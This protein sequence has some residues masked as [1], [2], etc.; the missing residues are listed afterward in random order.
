MKY[1]GKAIMLIRK[2]NPG[3]PDFVNL[4][5]MAFLNGGPSFTLNLKENVTI[6]PLALVV[7]L[8]SGK[9]GFSLFM[10]TMEML[11][12]QPMMMMIGLLLTM[13]L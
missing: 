10:E 6:A 4:N 5:M 9:P 3:H 7:I 13:L 8:P 11:Q 1:V 2:K 12:F